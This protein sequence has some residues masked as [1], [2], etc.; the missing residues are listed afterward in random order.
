M[1]SSTAGPLRTTP[2]KRMRCAPIHCH[3]GAALVLQAPQACTRAAGQRQDIATAAA[4]VLLSK[5]EQ[6]AHTRTSARRGHA[7]ELR[8]QRL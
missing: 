8:W 2:I 3:C 5:Q 6:H 4:R 7:L 1:L